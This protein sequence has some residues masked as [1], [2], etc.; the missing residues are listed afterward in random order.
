MRGYALVA[1]TSSTEHFLAEH[2]VATSCLHGDMPPKIRVAEYS[3]FIRDEAN[4]L[5]CTDAA[6]RGL[7]FSQVW[8]V[9]AGGCCCGHC[10]DTTG[11]HRST[12]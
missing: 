3:K 12:M 1:T 2:G 7:D 11:V 9:A 4:V 8:W 6:A 5:V 10:P